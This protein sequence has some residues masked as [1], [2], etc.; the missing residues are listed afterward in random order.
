MQ[1]LCFKADLMAPNKS[2]FSELN[3]EEEASREDKFI[4]Q[5]ISPFFEHFPFGTVHLCRMNEAVRKG[6]IKIGTI[7]IGPSLASVSFFVNSGNTMNQKISN[8]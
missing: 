4:D 5:T 3:E 1:I 2:T 7:F 8:H 6:F